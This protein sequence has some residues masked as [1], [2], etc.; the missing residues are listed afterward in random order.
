MVMVVVYILVAYRGRSVA[1]LMLTNWRLLRI[2]LRGMLAH[3]S[4]LGR[5]DREDLLLRLRLSV[6]VLR[7]LLTL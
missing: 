2:R 5:G 4:S 6:L 7:C 1:V 3:G